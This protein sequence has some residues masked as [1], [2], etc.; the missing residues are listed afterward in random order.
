MLWGR[1]E[2]IGQICA[3]MLTSCCLLYLSCCQRNFQHCQFSSSSERACVVLRFICPLMCQRTKYFMI[4]YRQ[5]YTSCTRTM[6]L[7]IFLKLLN[8]PFALPPIPIS[9]KHLKAYV[10]ALVCNTRKAY[11]HAFTNKFVAGRGD[12]NKFSQL[13]SSTC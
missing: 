2:I 9:S 3:E 13:A 11:N 10:S 1:R 7:V 12:F 8:L 6:K 4:P 5:D